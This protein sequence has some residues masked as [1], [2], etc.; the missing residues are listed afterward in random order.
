MFKWSSLNR[1]GCLTLLRKQEG[2]HRQQLKEKAYYV[3]IEFYL[4][5]Q[6]ESQIQPMSY[7]LHS[8]PTLSLCV[9]HCEGGMEG[10]VRLSLDS[11]QICCDPKGKAQIQLHFQ[12]SL[13]PLPA[14]RHPSILW[15]TVLCLRGGESQLYPLL[16]LPPLA[17]LTL[18]DIM[19]HASPALPPS[20]SL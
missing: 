5:K 4:C 14:Q 9:F 16:S 8:S 13:H 18:E 20:F 2:S 1:L 12:L 3:L 10:N 7:S 17:P 6:A 11:L 15:V 19:D